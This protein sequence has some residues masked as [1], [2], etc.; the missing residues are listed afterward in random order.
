MFLT[1]KQ[2]SRSL[3][4]NFM[5]YVQ[6]KNNLVFLARLP[7][8]SVNSNEDYKCYNSRLLL[9][10]LEISGNIKFLENSQP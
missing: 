9:I 10:I 6:K 5:H 3:C 2:L 8:I 7:G 4:F 1:N